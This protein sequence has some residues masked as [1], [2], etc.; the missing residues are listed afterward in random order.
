[1]FR[2]DY[3]LRYK[4]TSK[5][6]NNLWG[7][8]LAGGEGTRLKNLVKRLYG[9]HRPKQYCTLTGTRSLIKQ[10]INRV[11]K[12]ISSNNILTVVTSHHSKF[13]KEEL[14]NRPEETI[15]V[16]PCPRGTSAGILL[17]V[18]KIY[19][20]DPDS[21]VAIFPSDHFI[22]E[23]NKFINYVREASLFVERNPNLIVM[24]GI[25]PD[26]NETGLG[27]IER[28]EKINSFNDLNFLQIRKFWEKP[29]LVIADSLFA[30]G[31]L[32]NTFIVVGKSKTIIN[33]MENRLPQLSEAFAPIFKSLGTE[34]E[35]NTIEQFFKFIPEGNFS[36]DFLEKICDHLAVLEIPD[37]Y[38]SDWGEE[39][40]IMHDLERFNLSFSPKIVSYTET[41]ELFH[42]TEV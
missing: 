36:K 31:C 41:I 7:I 28:G 15:I 38:W 4:L 16:Q 1:M 42:S 10:T 11:S 6:K 12:I 40:R 33:Q 14:S 20:S 17:P 25:R 23:E 2:E 18:A 24:V 29:G 22:L 37:V 13:Y 5:P 27:W 21:I 9:Y 32:I 3:L 8:V 34:K 30:S 35:K 26:K 19:K 39:Q